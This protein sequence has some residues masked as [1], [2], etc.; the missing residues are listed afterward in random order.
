VVKIDFN[1]IAY[2]S[3]ELLKTDLNLHIRTLAAEHGIEAEQGSLQYRFSTLINGLAKKYGESV[4]VLIDE[5][6]KPIIE[7]LGKG[8]EELDIAKR[9]RDVLKSLFGVLK[10]GD[11]SA[12]LKLVFITGVSKFS[13]VS[14]FSELNNLSDLTMNRHYADMLGYTQNELESSFSGHIRQ[15]AEEMGW[16]PAQVIEHLQVFYNGYR[17]SEKNLR[18]YN[19][20]S[21]LNALKEMTFKNYWFETG[22]P[23][24]LVNLLNENNWYLPEIEAIYASESVFSVYELENLQPESLLFQTGYITICDSDEGLYSF[25][26]PNQEV[27]TA[28]LENLFHSY[29]KGLRDAS[30]FILLPRYLRSE[31][32]EAFIETMTAIFASIPYVLESKRDESYFHTIF[33]LMICASGV[34][35]R[36]EVLNC[37]GRIDL[38][39]EFPDKLYIIEFKCNQSAQAG[40]RQIHD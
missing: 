21:V 26:Y 40:I 2:E 25:R 20:F 27:K 10:D 34:T 38:L 35:A 9:N 37:K 30:R 4:A 19:P 12:A 14:I 16:T 29:T 39:V 8:E 18:V 11:V 24:F 36:S 22:T 3:P 13:R 1:S 33:Y 32:L 23:T 15:F 7:H 17:F 31:D 28:F 6:D 5:Y